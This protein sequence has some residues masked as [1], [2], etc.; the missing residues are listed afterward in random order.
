MAA[1]LELGPRGG[2]EK[3]EEIDIEALI[4]A[5]LADEGRA[6]L[7]MPRMSAGQ[8]KQAKRLVEQHPGLRCESFGLG[9]DRQ[10]HLFKEAACASA[11]AATAST[12]PKG[13]AA[14]TASAAA[15]P[16]GTPA[17]AGAEQHWETATLEA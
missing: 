16:K 10:L 14:G 11:A 12:S 6:T 15:E 2:A 8:R 1:P 13:A 9:Q 4:A 17:R 7:E 5:F 3:E